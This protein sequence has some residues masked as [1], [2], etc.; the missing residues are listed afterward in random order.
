MG[1][2]DDNCDGVDVEICPDLL[3]AGI[4]AAAAAAFAILFTAI[5]MAGRRKKRSYDTKAVSTLKILTDLYWIGK[6]YL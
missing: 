3:L 4:A 2:V 1:I 5:T 6:T